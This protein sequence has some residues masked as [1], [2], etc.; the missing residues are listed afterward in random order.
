MVVLHVL[1]PGAVGG[2]ERLVQLLASG[3]SRSGEEAHVALVLEPDHANHPLFEKLAAGGVTAHSVLVSGRGYWRERA[4]LSELCRRLRPGV[5]HTH[6]YRPDLVDAPVARQLGIP[7]VTTVHGFTGGDWKNRVYERLQRR[8]YR[9]FD[10]VAVV[11]RPLVDRLT[12]SGVARSRIHLVQNA[13]QDTALLNDRATAR[14]ALGLALDG[15]VIGWVGRLSGEKG[16]DVLVDALAYL[17]DLPATVSMV[18]DGPER[19]ALASRARRLGVERLLR[20][21]GAIPDVGR[22][23]AA[24]D[25]FVLSSHTEGTPIV[26][27]EAMAAGVPIVTT[28]VGGI[29]DMLTPAEATLVPPADAVA[30]AAAIRAG[31]EAPALGRVRA[32]R[33]EARLR[34]D[35]AVGPWLDRY[36][37]IYRLVARKTVASRAVAGAR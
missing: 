15:F 20:L 25:I 28:S 35:F 3:Q 10:A 5:V 34:R 12:Q 24:F 37:A 9:R 36:A 21:H 7:T 2:L 27:F 32:Q 33:A 8:A 29:P 30:L 1:A 18:G 23:F 13:W 6:G 17:S 14:C 11:A 26:L 31:Y 4:L 19:R 16:P 22:E